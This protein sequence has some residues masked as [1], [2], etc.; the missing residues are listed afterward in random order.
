MM[1]DLMILNPLYRKR[2]YC[3]L[4]EINKDFPTSNLEC[5]KIVQKWARA[6]EN[7][8]DIFLHMVKS[9][10]VK[11]DCDVYTNNK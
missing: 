10:V 9:M 8:C 7:D 3:M 1:I 4:L 6:D 5:D 11:I 2:I